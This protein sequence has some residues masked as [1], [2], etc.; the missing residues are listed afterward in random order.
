MYGRTENQFSQMPG[1]TAELV[2]GLIESGFL[3]Y[4]DVRVLAPVPRNEQ[5]IVERGGDDVGAD[6]ALGESRGDRSRQAD[7]IEARMD[8]QRDPRPLA[9]G[10]G[11]AS[12]DGVSFLPRP[13]R[14]AMRSRV[15]SLFGSVGL[16]SAVFDENRLPNR[17][18][19]LD[20]AAGGAVG[21]VS[22]MAIAG[23]VLVA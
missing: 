5:M 13:T 10:V 9:F 18:P 1:V 4:E 16:A 19:P 22:A 12:A 23:G 15:P 21:L 17:L 8:G 14:R 7:R 20:R 2:E 6:P 11:A 3:S